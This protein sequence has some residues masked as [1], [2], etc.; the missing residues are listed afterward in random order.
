MIE[1]EGKIGGG[2]MRRLHNLTALERDLFLVD[3][4]TYVDDDHVLYIHTHQSTPSS[5]SLLYPFRRVCPQRQSA[6]WPNS[7]KPLINL[8]LLTFHRVSPCPLPLTRTTP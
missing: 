5:L 4:I 2:E 3:S 8:L 7:S 6:F 1:V